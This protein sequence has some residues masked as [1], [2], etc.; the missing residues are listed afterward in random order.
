[1][2]T[3]H[4]HPT[5]LLQPFPIPEWKWEVVIVNLITKMPRTMKQ[6]NSIMV[7]V[8]KLAKDVHFIPIKNTH[9]KTNIS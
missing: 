5:R 3:E 1:M 7:V 2:N 6:H 8:D 4:R 9:K